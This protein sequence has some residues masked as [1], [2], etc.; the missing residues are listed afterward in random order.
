MAM[1]TGRVAASV[2]TR[3]PDRM[4]KAAAAI[5][6][7]I[8]GQVYRP[9]ID[10]SMAAASS[11]NSRGS[12]APRRLTGRW[13]FRVVALVLVPVVARVVVAVA[14]EVNSIENRCD[15]SRMACLQRFD[16]TL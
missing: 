13:C 4:N 7:G 8:V 2:P 15:R 3:A 6:H 5:T 16:R 1:S 10:A 11:V 9:P 12:A 14:V